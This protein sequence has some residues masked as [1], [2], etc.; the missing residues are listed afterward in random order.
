MDRDS[1]EKLSILMMQL[2]AK[3]DESIAFVLD[4]DTDGTFEN[5]KLIAGKI[6]ASFYL[7]IE[8]KLW[9]KYPELLPEAMEGTYKID[10]KIY[11]PRF[12]DPKD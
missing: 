7:D 5:Y 9:K 10:P 6:M 8:N 12:Y 4:H 2:N 1:A 11:E 3:M